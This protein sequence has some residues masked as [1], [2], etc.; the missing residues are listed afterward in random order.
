MPALGVPAL[1]LEPKYCK[2][3]ARW[4]RFAARSV[5]TALSYEG[6]ARVY[7]TAVRPVSPIDLH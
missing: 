3:S 5:G 2:F 7:R 1:S 6:L 4:P